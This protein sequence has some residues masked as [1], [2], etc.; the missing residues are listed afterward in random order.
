MANHYRHHRPF[1]YHYRP[2]HHHHRCPLCHLHRRYDR[3]P[4]QHPQ[5]HIILIV[6]ERM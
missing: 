6:K 2:R 5:H 3:R 1:C 4:R